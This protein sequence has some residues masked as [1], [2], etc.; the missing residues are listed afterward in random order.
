[1]T[2]VF[3]IN[4]KAP[5]LKPKEV[6]ADLVQGKQIW[7]VTQRHGRKLIGT[8]AFFSQVS[9]ERA[10]M[11]YIVKMSKYLGFFKRNHPYVA[12]KLMDMLEE[13]RLKRTA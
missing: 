5:W 11:G 4:A 7:A 12:G 8:T 13:H 9:A 1:M 3:I 6:D 2:R 10:A